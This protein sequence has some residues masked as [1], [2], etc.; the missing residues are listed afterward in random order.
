[1]AASPLFPAGY[2]GKLSREDSSPAA[3]NGANAGRAFCNSVELASALQRAPAPHRAFGRTPV[4]RRAV[5]GAGRGGGSRGRDNGT[6]VAW[7]FSDEPQATAAEEQSRSAWRDPPPD[8]P[9]KG[10]EIRF[11]EPTQAHASCLVR[12]SIDPRPSRPR[13][14]SSARSRRRAPLRQGTRNADHRGERA[15]EAFAGARR[16]AR[17]GGAPRR[18]RDRLRRGGGMGLGAARSRPICRLSAAD[19]ARGAVI[20]DASCRR[21]AHAWLSGPEHQAAAAKRAFAR[22]AADHRAARGRLCGVGGRTASLVAPSRGRS[23]P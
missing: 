8:L 18:E 23:F 15:A 4:F 19:R 2:N 17:D 10:E 9:H 11:R 1:M 20:A 13:G 3:T 5:V 7:A 6:A 14:G 16:A 21:A 12:P 22:R